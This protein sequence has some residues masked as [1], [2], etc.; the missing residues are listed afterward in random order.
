MGRCCRSR[1]DTTVPWRDYTRGSV[2]TPALT[3]SDPA[4]FLATYSAKKLGMEEAA[5]KATKEALAPIKAERKAAL[6][7]ISDAKKKDE[8]GTARDLKI[9]ALEA[10]NDIALAAMGAVAVAHGVKDTTDA[11]AYNMSKTQDADRLR[12]GLGSVRNCN[13]A[14]P[15]E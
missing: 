4:D 15:A 5:Y 12:R 14:S 8:P 1:T 2:F 7:G 11:L 13:G 9:A 6:K 3:A 10:K